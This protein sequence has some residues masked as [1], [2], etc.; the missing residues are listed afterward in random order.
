MAEVK[1]IGQVSVAVAGIAK[2]AAPVVSLPTERSVPRQNLGDYTWLIY[3][4]KKIGK[5]SL[6]AQFEDALFMMFEP[7]G[8]GLSIFQKNVTTW[9]EFKQYIKLLR[10][11]DDFKTIIIDTADIA[12][13]RCMAYVGRRE[14]FSHPS[15]MNDFGKSW[16]TVAKEFQDTILGLVATGRGVMFISHAKESEFTEASGRTYNKI[17]PT[18]SNQVRNFV[19]GFVDIIGY[20]GYY[21]TERLL[22]IEGSDSIDAGR[23]IDSRF[24]V[25]GTK[26]RVYSIPMGESAAEGYMNILKAFNNEQEESF[27]PEVESALTTAKKKMA[28][29]R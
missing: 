10:E 7:G 18:M 9:E 23:R 14:G 19:S 17:I 4:E 1:K 20:Y 21:A 15:E 27:K 28:N 22:T 13:E 3:G 24:L 5:T 25:T 16:Q 29:R 12:Y 8:K 11:V 2:P 6:A 26:E